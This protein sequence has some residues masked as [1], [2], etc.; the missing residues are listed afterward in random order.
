ML[1]TF[2][3]IFILTLFSCSSN[4]HKM[5]NVSKEIDS[6]ST[7]YAKPLIIESKDEGWGADIRLSFTESSTTDKGTTYLVNS[8]YDN[9]NVGFKMTVPKGGLAKLLIKSDGQNSDNFIHLLQKLYKQKL[10]PTTKFIDSLT[11]DCLP[12]SELN[13]KGEKDVVLA[14]ERKLFFQGLNE[15]DYAELYLNINDEEHWIELKEKDMDYRSSLI[16]LMTRK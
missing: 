8:I 13:Q 16:K 9:R 6:T 12:L 14:A 4:Q 2:A 7:L 11:V 10:D 1:K 3:T 15:D 5:D